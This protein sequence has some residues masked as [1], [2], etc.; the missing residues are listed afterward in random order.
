MV[1]KVVAVVMRQMRSFQFLHLMKQ[2]PSFEI[3]RK[4]SCSYKTDDASL[5]RPED[6][7][8]E[9]LFIHHTQ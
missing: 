5:S 2:S 7:E 6:L 1:K 9:L 4:Y 3:I 8:R